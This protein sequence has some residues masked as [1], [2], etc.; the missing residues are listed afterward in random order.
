MSD[1]EDGDFNDYDYNDEYYENEDADADED[2]DDENGDDEK[3]GKFEQDSEYEDEADLPEGDEGDGQK[4]MEEIGAWGRSAGTVL[5]SASTKGASPAEKFKTIVHAMFQKL[6]ADEQD[7][8]EKRFTEK[9]LTTLIDNVY[10][11][12]KPEYKNPMAYILGCVGS[13]EGKR[14]DKVNIDKVKEFLP[15]DETVTLPDII[16]YAYL[17]KKIMS[18]TPE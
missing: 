11:L 17:W 10:K 14:I 8:A 18:I 9:R 13:N 1:Y 7:R 12:K 16:R 15:A 3:E 4:F 5:V 2:D 6:K